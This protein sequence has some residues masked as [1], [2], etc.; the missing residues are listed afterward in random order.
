MDNLDNFI[1]SAGGQQPAAAPQPQVAPQ[2]VPVQVP[3]QAP[4]QQPAV[5]PQP[6]FGPSGKP[7]APQQVVDLLAS[8]PPGADVAKFRAQFEQQYDLS[9]VPVAAPQQAAPAPAPVQVPVQ[10]PVQA[11]AQAPV[12]VQQPAAPPAVLPQPTAMPAPA[13]AGDGQPVSAG[14]QPTPA[15]P[16]QAPLRASA[17]AAKGV[18]KADRLK[19]AIAMVQS[20]RYTIEDAERYYDPKA[21]AE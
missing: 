19:L 11:P 9:N 14:Y 3:V 18:S 1:M 12:Q 17:K 4:V 7:F 13:R 10:Q 6:G 16:G 20:G 21:S 5:A 15:Q 8:P 2:Q